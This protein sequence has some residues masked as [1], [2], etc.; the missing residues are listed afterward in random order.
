VRRVLQNQTPQQVAQRLVENS[1]LV[2]STR[3]AQILD[4]GY[5]NSGDPSVAITQALA[6]LY[7]T[8]SRQMQD[9][10]STEDN[11][12][13]R[14]AQARFAVFGY[15]IPPD[16]TFTPRIA[17]G[18]VKS[19]AYNGTRAPAFTNFYGLLDHYH[20]YRLAD[21][22][23]PERWQD[24]P[25]AFDMSTPLNLVSTNDITG[26]N[27]GSPLL[28]RDLEVVGLIF[29]SNIEALPNTYLY[30]DRAARAISVDGR[31]ILEALEHVYQADRVA[32]ELTS[33]RMVPG[34][35]AAEQVGEGR[36]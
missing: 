4:D 32:V 30:T 15:S 24:V 3:F 16:A 12:N 10:Q 7:F 28:N 23:L 20:S 17:D 8:V 6:P 31:G 14:L 22:D 35:A 19:Y 13:A 34:Q 18:V 36:Q 25:D 5:L 29:D 1:A 11:L 2:D 9:Y 27:S 33:G 26:G 21:W